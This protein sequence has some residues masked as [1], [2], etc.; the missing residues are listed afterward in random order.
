VR[1]SKKNTAVRLPLPGPWLCSASFVR[2][3]RGIWAPR[4]VQD[5]GFHERVAA[6]VS[7][8]LRTPTGRAS[9]KNG[10]PTGP[11]RCFL[12]FSGES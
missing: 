4:K 11:D 6:Y 5:S 12:V 9:E 1:P 2:V 10:Q 3:M 7:V 8:R